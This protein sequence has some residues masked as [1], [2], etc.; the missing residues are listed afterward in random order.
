MSSVGARSGTRDRVIGA[1]KTRFLKLSSGV[2][3]G[4]KSLSDF[5][6]ST[7]LETLPSSFP[8]FMTGASLQSRVSSRLQ[9]GRPPQQ[10]ID[11]GGGLLVYFSEALVHV[12]ALKMRP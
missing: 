12:A 1:M 3:R 6:T 8:A 4:V 9:G 2:L 11:H 7:P 10:V 5:I